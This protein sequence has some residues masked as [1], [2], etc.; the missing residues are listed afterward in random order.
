MLDRANSIDQESTRKS[1]EKDDL[2]FRL[3]DGID[4]H[5]SAI[6]GAIIHNMSL[7]EEGHGFSGHKMIQ[8]EG[9]FIDFLKKCDGKTTYGELIQIL[10]G[11][12]G[13][14]FG[15][16]YAK[17]AAIGAIKDQLVHTSTQPLAD[18]DI[19]CSGSDRS[20]QPL[21]LT[22]EIIETCNFS[23]DHC[24]YSSSPFKKGRL[25]LEE[26]K[27]I[28]RKAAK[29]GVRVIEITGGECTIHPNFRE[30]LQF[31]TQTFELVGIISNGYRL[32]NSPE[33]AE[34][35]GSFENLIIQ[36]SMD[37]LA[38]N[39]NIFRKHKKSWEA[40]EKAVKAMVSYGRNVRIAMS[41]HEDNIEDIPAMVKNAEDWGAL[42]I[43]FAPV[44]KIGRGCNVT[45]PG[46][47]TKEI[48]ESIRMQL[49]PHKD[50]N[51]LTQ[52]AA[53]PEE[54]EHK[55]ASNCGAGWR[56][57]AVDYDGEVRACNFS[58][59]SKK[60]GSIINDDYETIFGQHANFLFNNAP[61]PGGELCVG[62]DYFL[63][64]KGCFV[65]AFM[66]SETDYPECPWRR[67]WFPE[68]SLEM[69]ADRKCV[70]SSQDAIRRL[71][72]GSKTQACSSCQTCH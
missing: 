18:R 15:P 34:F 25:E 59:D 43:A 62:C 53:V 33:L 48:V 5:R 26:A 72:Q 32:G 61:S 23:C 52:T 16:A 20:F 38:K 39:H 10:S 71:P 57:F 56:T 66:V 46:L 69:D 19:M 44:A 30:I 17:Q 47:G 31:A 6:G 36:I 49:R 64:C 51:V 41:V 4:L 42:N 65:K 55:E 67:H 58:R 40:C 8:T 7:D 68:M 11:N 2:Y 63:N 29:S 1:L 45:D 12:L 9:Y 24:Y 70:Q 28:M 27:T 54:A 35:V 50:S 22:L 14:M 21:H 60:F 37:G 13:Q 3:I